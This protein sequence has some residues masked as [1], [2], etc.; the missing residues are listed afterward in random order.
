V[1][2]LE[3]GDKVQIEFSTIIKWLEER[4]DGVFMPF[5]IAIP[6][7]EAPGCAQASTTWSLSSEL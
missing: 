6:A 7:M 1:S 3:T 5:C 2:T 4:Y